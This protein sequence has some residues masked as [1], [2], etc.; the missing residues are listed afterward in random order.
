M[1]IDTLDSKQDSQRLEITDMGQLLGSKAPTTKYN[2]SESA[3]AMPLPNTTLNEQC[4]AYYNF[5]AGSCSEG[6]FQ[7]F[8]PVWIQICINYNLVWP[9]TSMRRKWDM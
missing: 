1:L 5:L 4:V 2:F 7:G 9:A 3:R 8:R 6:V